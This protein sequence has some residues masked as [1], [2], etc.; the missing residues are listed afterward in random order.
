MDV[1][2]LDGAQ[3]FLDATAELRASAPVLTNVLGSVP[4]G[5]AAGL[6][7]YETCHW[8]V[9]EDDAR[10]I[11][12]AFRTVPFPMVL[13]PMGDAAALALATVAAHDDATLPGAS[14]PED[15][16]RTLCAEIGRRTG[17]TAHDH[18]R[19]LI[20]ELG[21][22]VVPDVPGAPRR[23]EAADEDLVVHWN[24]LFHDE[25]GGPSSPD[26]AR[27]RLRQG[28]TWLWGDEGAT[29]SLAGHAEPISV[30]GGTLTRIGPVYTPLDRRRRG[31]AGAV[32]AA[33]SAHLRAE[34]SRVMLYTDAANPTS[35]GVYQRIGFRQVGDT[36]V[37]E[38]D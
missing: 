16:V 23:A 35:N 24:G 10:V 37:S 13:S 29:V 6:T 19:Q 4:A 17:R 26:G 14:G 21:D 32:T 28:Q 20:Y 25:V 22:L 30:P 3:E 36:L 8:W 27:V 2:R 7:P 33:L 9:V 11:G 5:V 38:F 1:V 18:G 34:G 15:V 31:Y 12:A